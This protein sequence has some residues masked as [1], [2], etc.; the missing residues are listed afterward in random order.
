MGAINIHD[1]E[2]AEEQQEEERLDERAEEQEQ[3]ENAR[4]MKPFK[5]TNCNKHEDN[6]FDKNKKPSQR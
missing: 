5:I 3:Y 4:K 6:H 2:R 1:E